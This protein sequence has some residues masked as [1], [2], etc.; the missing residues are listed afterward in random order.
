MKTLP[1]VV[2]LILL[3]GLLLSAC[4]AVSPVQEGGRLA[5]ATS[6]P[7]LTATQTPTPTPTVVPS[8]T[9]TITSP[10]S[11]TP[12]PLTATPTPTLTPI[13]TPTPTLPS[14]FISAP[15]P[16][17]GVER[18][19]LANLPALALPDWPRPAQD[20][21]LGI[22]FMKNAFFND[23]ELELNIAR[24]LGMRLKWA[25][26]VYA[27]GGQLERAARRF[28]EAG[29]VV[30]WRPR[31]FAYEHYP[32]WARD[33]RILQE[34]G[35]PPYIQVYNEPSLDAEWEDGPSKSGRKFRANLRVACQEI[36]NAGGFI[37]L[38][39]I[40][41][42]WLIDSL[43][44]IK[45]R[46]G[47]SILGRTFFVSHPY[48]MNHPPD[49]TEDPNGVLGFLYWADILQRELGFVPPIIAGEGGWKY[50]AD[51]DD[52]F[53]LVDEQ[54]HRDY[55]LEMFNWFRTGLLS[56]GQL[57]P[58]YLLAVCPWL[59]AAKLDS[60]AWYDSFAGDRTLTIE[61]VKAIP[62]FERKFSW[63]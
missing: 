17:P 16:T 34:A 62:P 39:F 22:H 52:R 19:E 14:T 60:N 8:F 2:I 37:G 4:Q 53:P 56:N 61:A 33:V 47:E 23:D 43:N 57:L 3:L 1:N 11:S 29:M 50:E 6:T 51:D 9:P 32:H 54:L 7:L 40:H 24:A 58:D 46:G 63:E 27:E 41:E 15:S 48:G 28:K 42:K 26:V 45:E 31:L 44:D 10:P 25:L 35:L 18:F 5:R 59:I 12:T 20:N 13:P 30:V 49:Y 55:H 36:Y 21:G 38:Q